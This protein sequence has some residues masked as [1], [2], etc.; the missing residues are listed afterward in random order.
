MPVTFLST[1]HFTLLHWD[2]LQK[3]KLD[4]MLIQYLSLF[5]SP[6][7]LFLSLQVKQSPSFCFSF[8][9]HTSFSVTDS[10][11]SQGRK[12]SLYRTHLLLDMFPVWKAVDL[13]ET[14]ITIFRK[15]YCSSKVVIEVVGQ[16]LV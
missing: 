7:I 8:F 6:P 1:S 9:I 4:E 3:N 12:Q 2:D 16:R 14:L 11:S 5:R 15:I 10:L 13:S